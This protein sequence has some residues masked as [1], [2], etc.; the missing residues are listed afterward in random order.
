MVR[1]PQGTTTRPQK[2]ART[3]AMHRKIGESEVQES[4]SQ[5]KASGAGAVEHSAPYFTVL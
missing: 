2:K 3:A 1:R 5:S 4:R